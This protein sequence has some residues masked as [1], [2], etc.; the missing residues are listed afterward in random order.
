MRDH[1]LAQEGDALPLVA[2][3]GYPP[4]VRR[5]SRSASDARRARQ[6]SSAE[7]CC[8]GKTVHIPDVLADPE[9]TTRRE[10]AEIGGVP[11]DARRAAA[12]RRTS[13]SASSCCC[14]RTVAAVHR[15]ADRAGHDLRRPGGHRHRER[16]AVRRG[17]GA[18][19]RSERVAGA[20][21]RD[22]RG[23]QGHQPLDRSICSRCSTRWSRSRRGCARPTSAL[24]FRC[25]G[26]ALSTSRANYGFRRTIEDSSERTPIAPGRRHAGRPG[27]RCEGRAV[28][29]PDVLADPEYTL[30]RIAERRRRPHR[31]LACRCCAKATPIGVI[32]H[33]PRRR[34]GR[35]PT[36]RSSW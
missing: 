22:R 3:Y 25:D 36:S 27:R 19:R 35:S 2:S 12:A 10:V 14:A 8:E 34:C 20:A 9:Y 29:I 17:A 31:C 16:A 26:R 23:A 11:H 4:R 13:R 30:R 32:V 28:H 5:V 15:Q 33:L 18:H 6:R 24:M 21:D 7:R 1:L